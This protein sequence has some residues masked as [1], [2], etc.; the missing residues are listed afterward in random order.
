MSLLSIAQRVADEIGLPR[1]GAL[2]S[3]ADQLAR[4]MYALA[5]AALEELGKL[6]WPDLDTAYT[7][8]TVVDQVAYPLPAD[9]ARFAT[10][11]AFVTAE[12]YQARGAL[13]ANEWARRRNGMSSLT[14]QLRYR[15]FGYPRRIQFVPAPQ[16]VQ[17]ITIEY[18]TANLV[19]GKDAT[20]KPLYA[21]DTDTSIVPEELVRKG[22][23]WRI[24]HAK[25]LDYSEDF[26]AYLTSVAELFAQQLSL[27]STP[28]AY[29]SRFGDDDFLG[30]P[31]VP[32][33]G[34]GS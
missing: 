3:G 10:D 22:L 24:K 29:R 5:N 19:V 9:Y 27:G 30:S 8:N 34:Y 18:L 4:Q 14:G 2:A 21:A 26:N 13:S 16:K 11:T 1:P 33:T 15:V 25:G 6:N 32:D 20:R 28:V 7:F 23:K 31:Y 17:S 12:Y